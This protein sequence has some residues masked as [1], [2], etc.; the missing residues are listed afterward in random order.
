MLFY[1]HHYTEPYTLNTMKPIVQQGNPVLR[2]V[3]QYIEPS[4]I[5]SPETQSLIADMHAALAT[6]RDGVALAAPQIG[7][8]FQIFVVS[9]V[10]FKDPKGHPLVYINPEI[11]EH[12]EDTQWLEEGCLSC[13]W[14]IG[15]VKRSL[16]A[17]IRAYDE[18]GVQFEETADGLLAHIFQHETDHL[19]G[20][21]FI[22]KARNLRDMTEKEIQEAMS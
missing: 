20:T 10:I 11:I 2:A 21:L 5:S 18:H 9:P 4:Y 12:S 6:Q 16:T 3:A 15:E 14:K 19:H 8:S 7:E 13:R 1:L 22:D 17:T